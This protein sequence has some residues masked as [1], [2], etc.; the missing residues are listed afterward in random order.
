MS[1]LFRKAAAGFAFAILFTVLAGNASAQSV[2]VVMEKLNRHYKT[3]ESLKAGVKMDKYNSQLDEHDVY[4]G[5]MILLPK[6][7]KRS[8]VYARIDWTKPRVESLAIIGNDYMLYTP[9]IKQVIKGSTS[10]AK[11]GVPTGALDFMSMSRAQLKENYEIDIAG[12]ETVE[13]G[14]NTSHL[15][16]TPL[17][18]G[19]YKLA[20]IWV[21]VDGMIRMARVTEKNNDTN[22]VFLNSAVKNKKIDSSAFRIKTAPGTKTVTG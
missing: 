14:T 15:L 5:S 20:E 18:G 2:N 13:G 1:N 17:K 4:V 10:T 8:Q 22:T 6:T 16:L 21:D 19:N 3:L 12:E 7:A 11:K 9:G